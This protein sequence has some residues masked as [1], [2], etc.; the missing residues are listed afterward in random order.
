[1]GWMDG[2]KLNFYIFSRFIRRA[3]SNNS[4]GSPRRRSSVKQDEFI[5]W[6]E[7]Q[8]SEQDDDPLRDAFTLLDTDK[9]GF[10]KKVYR[11]WS[12]FQIAGCHAEQFRNLPLQ[13]PKQ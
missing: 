12:Y 4:T 6:M 3:S 10:L 1:M 11:Q 9:D 8:T 2:V 13:L 5:E 7:E